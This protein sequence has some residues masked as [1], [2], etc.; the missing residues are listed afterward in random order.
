MKKIFTLIV[1]TLL[2]ATTTQ[3]QNVTINKTDGTQVTF[4]ANEIKNIQFVP[5]E[6]NNPSTPDTPKPF[7]SFTGWLTVRNNMWFPQDTYVGDGAKVEVFLEN[8]KATINFSHSMYG[9]G[10]FDVTMGANHSITGSGK[11][12]AAVLGDQ[13][14]DA[15][16]TGNTDVIE[17]TIPD[18]MGG[19]TVIWHRGDTPLV[20]ALPGT[21]DGNNTIVVGGPT[22]SYTAENVSYTIEANEDGTINVTTSKEEYKNTAMGDMVISPFTIKNLSFD[23]TNQVYTRDYSQDSISTHVSGATING[24]FVFGEGSNITVKREK[25]GSI[26]IQNTYKLGKMPLLINGTFKGTKESSLPF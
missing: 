13:A 9:E 18:L 16:L 24:D 11:L 15:T 14:L 3:A 20:Y 26:T 2:A 10:H 5:E 17:I 25:D 19:T 22:N 4:K 6:P 21:Y 1:A 23:E 8:N 12:Q 7:H